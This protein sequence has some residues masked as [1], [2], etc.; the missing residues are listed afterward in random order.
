[1]ASEID[2]AERAVQRGGPLVEGVEVDECRTDRI[3]DVDAAFEG[4]GHQ[5]APRPRPRPWCLLSTPMTER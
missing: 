2:K 1:M 5:L 3:R 4:V